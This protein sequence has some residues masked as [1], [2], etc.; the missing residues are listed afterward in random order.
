MERFEDIKGNSPTKA[1][2][3]IKMKKKTLWTG[4]QRKRKQEREI[5]KKKGREFEEEPKHSKE[6]KKKS[7][8]EEIAGEVIAG[9]DRN[10]R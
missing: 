5:A 4:K 9:F 7:K 8:E 1:E 2:A 3:H 10:L 6:E